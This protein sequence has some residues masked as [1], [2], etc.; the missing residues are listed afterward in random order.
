MQNWM[1]CS[2]G[3]FGFHLAWLRVTWLAGHCFCTPSACV[4][5]DPVLEIM[6]T[7]DSIRCVVVLQLELVVHVTNKAGIA[8][9]CVAT[10]HYF[11]TVRIF[12]EASSCCCLTLSSAGNA[13]ICVLPCMAPVLRAGLRPFTWIEMLCTKSCIVYHATHIRR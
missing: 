5:I 12:D 13:R 2:V 8:W 11:G 7:Q 1:H 4:I 9:N 10:F 6:R 3:S